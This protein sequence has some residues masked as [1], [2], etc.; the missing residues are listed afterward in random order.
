MRLLLMFFTLF[1]LCYSSPAQDEV[2]LKDDS[3]Q[4]LL[5]QNISDS[6]KVKI[7][8][9]LHFIWKNKSFER[10]IDYSKQAI[11]L[12]ERSK[13]SKYTL[14]LRYQLGFA[15]MQ[16]GDAIRSIEIFQQIIKELDGKDPLGYST[17]LA[18]IA[19]NYENQEDYKSALEYQIK[20]SDIYESLLTQDSVHDSRAHLGNPHKLSQYYLKNKQIDSAFFY[21]EIALK[22]LNHEN[23]TEWNQFF[24]WYIKTLMGDIFSAQ[25]N[26]PTAFEYY[27]QAEKE[28]IHYHSLKYNYIGDLIPIYLARAQIYHLQGKWKKAIHEALKSY[29]LADTLKA[30]PGIKESAL[31]LKSLYRKSGQ[32]DSALIYYEIATAVKDS[33]FNADIAR[34][35]DVL[36]FAEEKRNQEISILQQ[37]KSFQKKQLYLS[38][39]ILLSIILVASL[40]RQNRIKQKA[41]QL[42]ELE[43]KEVFRQRDQLVREVD[44]LEI[45]A[46]KAQLNPHFIFNCLNNIDAF[47]YSNDKYKATTYLNK[48]AKLLRNIL[49]GSDTNTIDINRDIQSLKLY[50]EL[51]ELRNNYKFATIY[52]IDPEI[53]PSGLQVPPLIIQP[54]VE[55]AIIHGLKNR[56]D[57]NGLLKI[58]I[59]LVD[60]FLEYTVEDNGK[61]RAAADQLNKLK[62]DENKSYGVTLVKSRL[63]LFNHEE[64]P[65]IRTDDIIKDNVV[66][67]TKVTIQ[68]KKVS[69]QHN[70]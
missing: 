47:I 54:I 56:S 17:A 29:A 40:Y 18:F 27:N 8:E 26:F 9:D 31:L 20:A 52:S 21:G 45:Q 41:N 63:K 44:R 19:M 2:M 62:S 68:L 67:G 28:I 66:V 33:L 51:E 53:E 43:N 34:K 61:G 3:L 50:I 6:H 58:S 69:E 1:A 38:S 11:A 39:G 57:Q 30:L 10:S 23:L 7:L 32:T 64:S 42:L 16:A 13:S 65:S 22:R 49:D 46:F 15:Y 12:A 14:G 5:H 36:E 35:I 24:S 70:I 60:G 37:E 48:F 55:N 4:Q 59:Q 25:D